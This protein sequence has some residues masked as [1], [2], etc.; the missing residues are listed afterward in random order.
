[1]EWIIG[2]G[3]I[4]YLLYGIGF[5]SGVLWQFDNRRLFRTSAKSKG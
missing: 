5:W 3:I 4:A 1:M 2:T